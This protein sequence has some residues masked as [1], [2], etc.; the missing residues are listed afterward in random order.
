MF[1]S[2]KSRFGIPGVI[3]VIALVFAMIG[4]AYAASSE[5]GKATASAKA[6][7]G[8][9][10]PRGKTG[11]PGP[12]GPAG[13]AGSPGPAGLKGAGGADGPKGATGPQGPQ[14]SQGPAGATGA[15]GADGA[16]G[17]SGATGFSGF[18]ETLPSG[19]TETGYWALEPMTKEGG[20]ALS[21]LSYPIPLAAP[22]Q[23]SSNLHYLKAG[24]GPTQECPGSANNPQAA[25]G[26][27]CIY[28][29][30]E[31]GLT[32]A[33]V[34]PQSTA[35]GLLIGIFEEVNEPGAFGSFAV[36]AP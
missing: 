30:N 9:R 14:G 15:T 25:P 11:P 8:P 34:G 19:K 33:I 35:G 29:L 1:S 10:G 17:A 16:T 28:A 7:R 27:L 13:P 24:E 3:A 12:Q 2:F 20:Q 36:T 22:I 32:T 5:S 23:Q 4:G 26:Q 6:K 18:T 21:A 31:S